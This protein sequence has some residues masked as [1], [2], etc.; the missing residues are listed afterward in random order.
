MNS[1]QAKI[2]NNQN[3][4]TC[5]STSLSLRSTER[6]VVGY[7]AESHSSVKNVPVPNTF[8]G[9]YHNEKLDAALRDLNNVIPGR[10]RSGSTPVEIVQ[11]ATTFIQKFTKTVQTFTKTVQT[12]TDTTRAHPM[13]NS[14]A[15]Q[16]SGT[17]PFPTHNA[18]TA[19]LATSSRPDSAQSSPKA[20]ERVETDK[21]SPRATD[22][23]APD[24]TMKI[25]R[26]SDQKISGGEGTRQPKKT[27]IMAKHHLE[28]LPEVQL[29]GIPKNSSTPTKKTKNKKKLASMR[30]YLAIEREQVTR[31]HRLLGLNKLSK[32][33][34][35]QVI[36]NYMQLCQQKHQKIL[37]SNN[38]NWDRSIDYHRDVSANI[39]GSDHAIQEKIRRDMEAQTIEFLRRT[40]DRDPR[41]IILLPHISH[42]GFSSKRKVVSGIIRLIEDCI[43][44]HKP[45]HGYS[46]IF[47]HHR[48]FCLSQWDDSI[49]SSKDL[50]KSL[51]ST[52][53][54][55]TSGSLPGYLGGSSNCSNLESYNS[56]RPSFPSKGLP[57]TNNSPNL[58]GSRDKSRATP[59]PFGSRWMQQEGGLT[60][61][62]SGWMQQERGWTQANSQFP[63][64]TTA[65][66][67]SQAF[68]SR[69]TTFQG[70][71]YAS[72]LIPDSELTL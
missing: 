67:S 1:S 26:S 19:S 28:H 32:A 58:L 57:T 33:S 64:Q 50:S 61:Q 71:Q 30:D 68:P 36:Y 54:S 46:D 11:S 23:D 37:E 65:G 17:A 55:E 22:Q 3:L 52:L 39:T 24:D 40:I 47:E 5:E 4:N 41:A 29:T 72:I 60:Q 21:I 20:V 10:F 35:Y 56:T 25:I 14:E 38:P 18:A 27:P 13:M 44:K 8:I 9:V 62:E 15:G 53:R 49:S 45:E 70:T 59:L 31:I 16:S 2:V 43:E 63:P 42:H 66:S 7:Y 6:D 51:R 48:H 34:T 69:E 12:F